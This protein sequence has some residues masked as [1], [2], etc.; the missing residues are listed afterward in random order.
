MNYV[1][2][3]ITRECTTLDVNGNP[4]DTPSLKFIWQLGETQDGAQPVTITP[5]FIS[6]GMYQVVFIVTDRRGGVV[7][8]RW[9]TDGD[10]DVAKEGRLYVKPSVF[11]VSNG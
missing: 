11:D 9:D 3:K 8:Y 4:V 1:G 10:I 6:T 2:Q 5:T 7:Y